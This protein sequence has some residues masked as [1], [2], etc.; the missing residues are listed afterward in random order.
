MLAA[1]TT[2]RK[3]RA[4]NPAQPCT[5][6][7]RLWRPFVAAASPRCPLW[8]DL[9]APC[10]SRRDAYAMH[11]SS[12]TASLVKLLCDPGIVKNSGLPR[13]Q[14]PDIPPPMSA[15]ACT[16]TTVSNGV[17]PTEL[18]ACTSAPPCK[19]REKTSTDVHACNAR[20]SGG[21]WVPN[22]GRHTAKGSSSSTLETVL[23]LF[24]RIP[25][26]KV[27]RGAPR[28]RDGEAGGAQKEA[29]FALLR[30]VRLGVW[31]V[32]CPPYRLL[33]ATG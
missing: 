30:G 3:E 11:L 8:P 7:A 23:A 18:R 9:E 24:L 15:T 17:N 31:H 29:V 28:P 33:L 20:M 2:S 5:K 32:F 25:S 12:L 26:S 14:V 27:C 10:H 1:A 13:L 21:S 6:F 22:I 16:P 19:S 4:S